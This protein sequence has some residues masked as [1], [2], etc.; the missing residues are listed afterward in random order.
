MSARAM[1]FCRF[2]EMKSKTE[3]KG[4]QNGRGGIFTEST[5]QGRGR[6]GP[7]RGVEHLQPV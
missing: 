3:T 5:A 7:W 2:I 1:W 6:V 4:Q